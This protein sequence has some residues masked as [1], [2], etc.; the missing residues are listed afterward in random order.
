[1]RRLTLY[2]RVVLDTNILIN[3]LITKGTPP[4]N[5]YQAWLNGE[6]EVV[7]TAAQ[8]AEIRDVLVR[9]RLKR[10]IHTDEAVAIVE[11]IDAYALVLTDAP[12]VD[13]S[14][15]PNDNPILAAVFAG[16]VDLIISGDKKH[17]LALREVQGVPVVTAREAAERISDFIAEP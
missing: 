8:I 9:P 2:V 17:M 10:F 16:K 13:I 15:D 6:I 14:P 7:M 1:M 3:T 12:V 5:L 11:N 4:D